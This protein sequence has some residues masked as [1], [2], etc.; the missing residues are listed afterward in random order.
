MKRR[1]IFR[2]YNAVLG[3][4]FLV[5]LAFGVSSVIVMIRSDGFVPIGEIL[6]RQQTDAILFNSPLS[7]PYNHKIT[8]HKKRAAKIG[9]STEFKTTLKKSWA[10]LTAEKR[11]LARKTTRIGAFKQI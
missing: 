10:H 11:G 4:V 2:S 1:N 7:S 3:L 8:L 5:F 6:D 9:R